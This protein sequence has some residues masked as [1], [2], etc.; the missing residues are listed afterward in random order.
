MD[1]PA[2]VP[3]ALFLLLAFTLA[4]LVHA[5]WLRSSWSTRFARPLDGYR[6]L[7]GKRLLGNN[8]TWRGFLGMIP[9]VGLAFLLLRILGTLLPGGWPDSLWNFNP[10]EYALLGCW[11]GFGFMAGELPNSFCKRRFD[12]AP[13]LAPAHPFGWAVCFLIDRLDSIAGAFL[14]LAIVVPT[15]LEVVLYLVLV[16]SVVHWLFSVL[17]YRLGV[18]ARPA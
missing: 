6:T 11:I 17:L 18:K 16:G 13:G 10:L 8:K 1:R 7:A 2:P 14:A 3:C 5:W 9:A 4:G 15:P 12:I